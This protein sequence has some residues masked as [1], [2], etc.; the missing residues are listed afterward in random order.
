MTNKRDFAINILKQLLTALHEK[1]FADVVNIV[2]EC[3]LSVDDIIECVQGTVELNEFDSI[4]E[5]LE[6]N[7]AFVTNEGRE[8]FQIDY[9]IEADGGNDLPLIIQLKIESQG[10]SRRTFLDIEPY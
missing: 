1:R 2:D 8:P 7:I 3:T 10:D 9:Y 4:D 5:Y 6:E